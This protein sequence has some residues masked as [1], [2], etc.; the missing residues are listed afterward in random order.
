MTGTTEGHPVLQCVVLIVLVLTPPD[1]APP[2]RM[3]QV[4]P[5]LVTEQDLTPVHVCPPE[6]TATPGQTSP[7]MSL[8]QQGT[9]SRTMTPQPDVM[10]AVADGPLINEG[11]GGHPQLSTDDLGGGA[12]VLQRLLLEGAIFTRTG[13]LGATRR[14]LLLDIVDGL[15]PLIQFDNDR[16]G[17]SKSPGHFALEYAAL[18]PGNGSSSVER[19]QLPSGRHGEKM[20]DIRKPAN[21]KAEFVITI[22]TQRTVLASA[23]RFFHLTCPCLP[24]C[25]PENSLVFGDFAVA[26]EEV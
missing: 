22:H 10:Q 5:G 3:V 1:L 2:V 23:Q 21:Y 8:C 19:C 14:G 20:A 12:P 17:Q 13:L 25:S 24:M 18:Q 4:E 11:V 16:V 6:M 9:N 26:W 7:A 15:G